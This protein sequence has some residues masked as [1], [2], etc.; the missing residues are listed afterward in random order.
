[1]DVQTVTVVITGISIIIGVILSLN[2]RKQEVETRQAQLFMQ[3]R[4]FSSEEYMKSYQDVMR[5]QDWTTWDEYMEN[6]STTVNPDAAAKVTHIAN[7]FNTIAFLAEEGLV[8]VQLIY[9]FNGPAF[10]NAWERLEPYVIGIRKHFN[11]PTYCASFEWLYKQFK[12]I[13]ET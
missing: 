9:R 8:D 4:T 10:I 1:M 7:T 13:Q 6:Y 11:F 3:Y 5:R 12:T 2:T